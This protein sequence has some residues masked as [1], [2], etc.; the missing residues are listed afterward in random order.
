MLEEF[1]FRFT[2]DDFGA[3]WDTFALPKTI[4]DQVYLWVHRLPM[5]SVADI[6]PIPFK[7]ASVNAYLDEQ[8]SVFEEQV[9]G[10]QKAFEAD[11]MD[12][13]AEVRSFGQYN[14]LSKIRLIADKARNIEVS[15]QC[16]VVV[17]GMLTDSCPA[18]NRRVH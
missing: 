15:R 5:T 8:K 3:R 14:D 7:V 4:A 9:T 13:D 10:R 16:T 17:A 11:A 6:C 12:L 1:G 2:K 18:E